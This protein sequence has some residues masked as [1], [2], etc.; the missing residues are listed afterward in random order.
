MNGSWP[1]MFPGK[2]SGF[3]LCGLRVSGFRIFMLDFY[4]WADLG[5]VGFS[6]GFF[7]VG[8]RLVKCNVSRSRVFKVQ[9]S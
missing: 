9:G 4:V 5:L 3:G 1:G 2:A 7:E 8:F 6:C